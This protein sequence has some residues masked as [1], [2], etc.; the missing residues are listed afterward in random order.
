MGPAAIAQEA[1]SAGDLTWCT[2]A[3]ELG[4]LVS[5]TS[6]D[7][8]VTTVGGSPPPE[9]LQ[10]RL[11]SQGSTGGGTHTTVPATAS[12]ALHQQTSLAQGSSFGQRMF[13]GDSQQ[14]MLRTGSRDASMTTAK[15]DVR[16]GSKYRVLEKLGEGGFGEIYRGVNIITHEAVAIKLEPLEGKHQHLLP[17][18]RLYKM[19]GPDGPKGAACEAN[20]SYGIPRVHWYGLEGDYYVMVI[21]MCGPSLEDVF[22]YCSRRFSLKTI[23]H[24]GIQMVSRLEQVHAKHVIH[25]DVKPDNFLLGIGNK[26]GNVYIIDFGLSKPYR[27]PRTLQHIGYR[28]GKHLLGTARYSSVHTHLGVEQSRRD[29]LE[30][31]AYILIYFLRGSLPWQVWL[32]LSYCF[33]SVPCGTSRFYS[34]SPPS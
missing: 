32:L 11:M 6:P 22:N 12:N 31:V 19:L 2:H 34:L 18:A 10:G 28:T 9:S 25:R 30:A 5:R 17:E 14:R 29:D 13:A 21:D 16:V 26:G 15:I 8:E 7:A 27:D 33:S 24:L 3:P 23:I 1:G 20:T 4:R